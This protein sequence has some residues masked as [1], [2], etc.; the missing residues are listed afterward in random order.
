MAM[1]PDTY[2]S[3]HRRIAR[4]TEAIL[5]EPSAPHTVKSL[6]DY[7]NLSPFHFHRIYRSMTGESLAETVRRLRLARAARRLTVSQDS[8]TTIALDVGYQSPQAFS[9]AFREFAGI[10]P[11]AFQARQQALMQPGH[12]SAPDVGLVELSSADV[13][14]LWHHGP[15]ESIGQTYRRLFDGLHPLDRGPAHAAQMGVFRGDPYRDEDFYYF[16]GVLASAVNYPSTVALE[17]VSLGGGLYAAYRLKGP[18]ALINPTFKAL[19]G[20][21]LPNSG[22]GL[23]HRPALEFYRPPLSS[24][25]RNHDVTDLMIPIRKV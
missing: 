9:R 8:I 6:S 11:T 13:V 7:A 1:R 12:S 22:Y 24:Q 15:V 4:V 19:F 18:F 20:G 2:A 5:A 14:G 3:Y 21:W 16:A 25:A 17:G 23:D 10:A